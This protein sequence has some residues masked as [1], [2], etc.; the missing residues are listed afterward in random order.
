MSYD[1]KIYDERIEG[2]IGT[3][4]CTGKVFS[5]EIQIQD[6]GT[7]AGTAWHDYPA[8]LWEPAGAVC[9][10]EAAYDN[11]VDARLTLEAMDLNEYEYQKYL[12]EKSDEWAEA[13]KRLEN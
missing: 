5:L 9:I 2:V 11:I 8:T 10:S 1:W 3:L 6:D 7:I 4:V 12:D 13:Q